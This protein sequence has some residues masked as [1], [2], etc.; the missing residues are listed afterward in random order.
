MCVYFFSGCKEITF[1]KIIF[2]KNDIMH[3][4][5]GEMSFFVVKFVFFG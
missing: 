3:N 1:F 5:L 2:V 4:I